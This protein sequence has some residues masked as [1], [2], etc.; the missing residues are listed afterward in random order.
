MASRE[1]RQAR[2]VIVTDRVVT[3]GHERREWERAKDLYCWQVP[4]GF[5]GISHPVLIVVDNLSHLKPLQD[6]GVALAHMAAVHPDDLTPGRTDHRAKMAWAAQVKAGD[7]QKVIKEAWDKGVLPAGVATLAL[8]RLKKPLGYVEAF[9]QSWVMASLVYGPMAINSLRPLER[10]TQIAVFGEDSRTKDLIAQDRK[11][12]REY[13]ADIVG[14][15]Q[16]R[17][18]DEP[19]GDLAISLT[20]KLLNA[21]M[22]QLLPKHEVPKSIDITD[23]EIVTRTGRRVSADAQKSA[24]GNTTERPAGSLS[25]TAFP[26]R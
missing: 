26:P 10:V 12:A 4:A 21:M 22:P 24:N 14:R 1:K 13:Y 7:A 20:Q 15:K 9:S 8:E 17:T 6:Y 18:D 19:K 5:D 11:R 23:L 2:T 16:V 25:G 3:P